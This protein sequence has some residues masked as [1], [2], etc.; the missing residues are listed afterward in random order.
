LLR[1]H[2]S[3]KVGDPVAYINPIHITF[4]QVESCSKGNRMRKLEIARIANQFTYDDPQEVSRG[5]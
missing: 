3:F 1:V 4:F 2:E 5:I